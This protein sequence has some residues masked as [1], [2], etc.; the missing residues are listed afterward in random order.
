VEKLKLSLPLNAT[1]TPGISTLGLPLALKGGELHSQFLYLWVEAIGTH[2][3]L[4]LV[5]PKSRS[6][7]GEQRKIVSVL[8]VELRLLS[9]EPVTLIFCY[10]LLLQVC[11][12]Q[13]VPCTAA[14]F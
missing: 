10:R 13:S 6:G 7:G 8:G 1:I 14:S 2:W 9:A 11:I 5:S 3:R 12:V 4:G